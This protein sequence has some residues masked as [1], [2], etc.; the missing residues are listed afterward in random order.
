MKKLALISVVGLA[1]S[2]CGGSGGGSNSDSTPTQPA[3]KPS[4]AIGSVEAVNAE[5]STLTVNGHTYRVSGVVYGDT[6]MQLADVEPKMMVQVGT[7]VRKASDDGF[8]VTLEPTITGRVT[9]IDYVKKTFTVNG[10]DLQ[11]DGLSDDIEINDWVMVSSLPT[12]DAGYRVLSVVELDVDNDY[13]VLDNDYELEGRITSIDEN[14]GTFELGTNITVSYDN[15]SQLSI[16]Q[17]VEV[18]GEMQNGIFM[19]HEVQVEDY[20]DLKN[21]SDVEGIVTWVAKDYSEFSLNYRGA[22]FIDNATRFEDGSKANLKQ[23]QEV[24][25]TSVMKN[26]KRIATVIEFE[27]PDFDDNN[28][29]QGKEFE[30]EG[31]V[32]NYD[33]EARTFEIERCENDADQLLNNTTVVID[34]QT[35]FQ[36]IEELNLNGARVEVEGVIINDQNIAR[37]VELDVYDN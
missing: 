27:Q 23:G 32:S 31:Y 14:A 7:D 10:V 16:G 1:L 3:V 21:D 33:A 25:V 19:A 35:R 6:S 11:F 18:E 29:W 8:L 34:A 15:I 17:W 30:C 24:E 9:A 13:P 36:G 12:A 2:G 20:D 28:Q 4:V 37:E 22:F 5:E 26:G